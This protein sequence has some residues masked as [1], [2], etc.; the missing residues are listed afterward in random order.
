MAKKVALHNVTLRK[1]DVLKIPLTEE[2]TFGKYQ[3]FFLL[4]AHCILKDRTSVCIVN[5]FKLVL[6]KGALCN[7][8][9]GCKQTKKSS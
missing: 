7:I 8:F 3:F 6:F 1:Q 5:A 9:I 2:L 4:F